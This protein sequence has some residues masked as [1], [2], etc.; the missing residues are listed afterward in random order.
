MGEGSNTAALNAGSMPPKNLAKGKGRERGVDCRDPSHGPKRV[1][2]AKMVCALT[3]TCP[4][5]E[6]GICGGGR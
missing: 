1:F 2:A 5:A 3:V 6:K 4:A